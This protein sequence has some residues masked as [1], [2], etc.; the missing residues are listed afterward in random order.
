MATSVAS[1]RSGQ[2]NSAVTN[3]G[4]V[5]AH[6]YSLI[7]AKELTHNLKKLRLVKIR[8]PWGQKEWNGDWSD[9]SEKWTPQLKE[10]V[11]FE[12]KEDGIFFISFEDYIKF[13]Y[14]TTICKYVEGG[15]LSVLEDE[16]A[17]GKYCLTR[18]TITKQYD[19][20]IMITLYQIHSRLVD[21]TMRGSYQYAPLKLILGKIVKEKIVDGR[22]VNPEQDVIA[23]VDG[24]YM[25]YNHTHIE[26][27][28]ISQGE[29]V[30]FTKAEWD[31]LNPHK[32]LILN[33]YAPD[34]LEIKRIPT[35]QQ[36]FSVYSRMD[37]WL[38]ARLSQENKY[39]LPAYATK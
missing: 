20:P 35:N 4:L 1:D 31:V 23:F 24:E 8:N 30:I 21:E 3:L 27:P 10:A 36:M 19:V 15:D 29:Y 14:I 32:K 33:I 38:G 9:K 18:F 16:H 17:P 25:Q 2:T 34:P 28:S 11:G 39:Q 6:A 5:D 7:A 12:A 37:G 22:S 26:L 13:F